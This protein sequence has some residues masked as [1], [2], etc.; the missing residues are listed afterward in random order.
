MTLL[1]IIF[2]GLLIR[3]ININQSLWL[4]EATTAIVAKMPLY[5]FFTKFMP[6]D[7]HP[8]LYYVVIHFWSLVAGYSEVALRIPSVIFGGL[9]IYLVYL[10]SK[11]LKFKNIFLAS[12]YLATSG[13]HIYY[14]QEA[15][16]YSLATFL[17]SLIVYLFIKKK[18][19]LFSIGL[20]A[21]FLS[22][23]LA[24]LILPS[25]IFYAVLERKNLKN[26]L[27]SCLPL[28]LTFLL[29]FPT[30]SK[31]L[32]SGIVL[33][34]SHSSW[35]NLLGPVTLK[36]IG[37]IPTKFIIGRVSIDNKL[38]YAVLIIILLVIF[39]Y[40]ISK[41]KNKMIWSWFGVSL[42]LG[43]TL[44]FFIPTLTYFRYLFIL[45]AFYLL[46][47]EGQNIVLTGKLQVLSVVIILFVNI[48]TSG[49]YLFNPRFHRENWREAARQIETKK[50]IFPSNS[51]KEALIYYSE[52]GI[53]GKGNQIITIDQ[54]SQSDKEVY[55][56]RYVWEIFDP[57]DITR[58]RLLD[59]GY[60]KT[61]E[62]NYN[63]V[64]IQKYEN[65][66]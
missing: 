28:F 14:S 13:L 17:V 61:S 10:I 58:L 31:Q 19:V 45:P 51:Q 47:A 48:L 52:A 32:M 8:P 64:V 9:T 23:Y 22:D 54:L 37:L 15:R 38:L 25:L 27:L 21:L 60:N 66:N 35:W 46:L 42:V 20:V 53:H 3:L 2:A 36:N 62:V 57:S 59:M 39:G 12:L 44:S 65:S 24:I 16:M 6:A 1:L 43:I 18:W 26:I 7:F 4:D 40:L 33:K 5:D 30:F 29:W 34:T 49:V 56:S 11:E 41:A 50:I 63:G 55:L